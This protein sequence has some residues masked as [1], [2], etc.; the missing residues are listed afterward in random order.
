MKRNNID[1]DKANQFIEEVKKDLSLAKKS[2]KIVGCWKFEVEM[3]TDILE[4]KIKEIEAMAKDRCPGV[5]R[6]ANPVPLETE[7]KKI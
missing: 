7:I 4:E 3:K 6:L 1:I 5:L 2:K